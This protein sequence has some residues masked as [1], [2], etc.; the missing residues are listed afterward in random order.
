M[1]KIER[2]S[3]KS[4]YVTPDEIPSFDFYSMILKAQEG[5]ETYKYSSQMYGF[6][7]RMMLPKGKPEGMIFKLFVYISPYDETTSMTVEVPVYGAKL[8]E[9]KPMGFPLDRPMYFDKTGSNM[10]WKDIVIFHKKIEDVN[11]TV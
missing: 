3:H 2:S 7:D 1:N 10:H 6:P 5:G 8:I 4:F 11:T 9:F